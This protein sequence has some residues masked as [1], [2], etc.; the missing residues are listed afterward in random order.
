[1]PN[2]NN[3]V[4]QH[5][6]GLYDKFHVSRKDGRDGQG[7]DRT[8]ATYLV[9]DLKYDPHARAGA[10]AYAESCQSHYPALAANINTI[11]GVLK[12][13]PF[14]WSTYLNVPVLVTFYK[15]DLTEATLV[16]ISKNGGYLKFTTIRGWSAWY[17]CNDV[18]LHDTLT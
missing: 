16:A 15:K 3:P 9:L 10:L 13:A 1:M 17:H 18:A 14:V 4:N 12:A 11:L 8:D 5:T 7:G 2:P 6:S